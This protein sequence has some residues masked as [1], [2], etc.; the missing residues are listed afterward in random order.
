MEKQGSLCLSQ[1]QRLKADMNKT[2]FCHA[3]TT[4]DWNGKSNTVAELRKWMNTLVPLKG[5]LGYVKMFAVV[6]PMA[7]HI[8]VIYTQ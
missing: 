3:T 5:K 8:Y 2:A 4:I 7:M 6:W 1:Q